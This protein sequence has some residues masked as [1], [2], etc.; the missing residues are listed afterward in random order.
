MTRPTAHAEDCMSDYGP[1]QR[2]CTCALSERQRIF[3][4]ERRVA[5]LEATE[6]RL[7]QVALEAIRLVHGSELGDDYSHEPCGECG[8]G[9]A[10]DLQHSLAKA[11][12]NG[13]TGLVWGLDMNVNR[14][15]WLAALAAANE[16][17]G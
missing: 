5:E 9:G 8:L 15:K 4:L 6:V 7:S 3:D 12:G 2:L 10:G 17:E 14:E 16:A 11:L 1:P 13:Y